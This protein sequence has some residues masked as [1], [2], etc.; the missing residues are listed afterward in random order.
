MEYED[1]VQFTNS[2]ET[3]N[4]SCHIYADTSANLEF[5]FCFRDKFL[6]CLE[7]LEK[8]IISEV[9]NCIGENCNNFT[10]LYITYYVNIFINFH[11]CISY[12]SRASAE[13]PILEGYKQGMK[14][15]SFVNLK[16]IIKTCKSC[17]FWKEESRNEERLT[18]RQL[19]HA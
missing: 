8:Y 5:K 11:L 18:H 10:N 19:V 17:L 1:I 3:E 9:S 14:L 4:M 7:C 6:C 16:L 13:K 12:L 2:I 15:K